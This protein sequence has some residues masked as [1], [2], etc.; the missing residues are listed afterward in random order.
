MPAR[1]SQA[2]LRGL[3]QYPGPVGS[4]DTVAA[5]LL[6]PGLQVGPSLLAD[7]A[8]GD[9]GRL[10]PIVRPG[11]LGRLRRTAPAVSALGQPATAPC[12]RPRGESVSERFRSI[13]QSAADNCRRQR[14]KERDSAER[15]QHKS[16]V[17][18]C[19]LLDASDSSYINSGYANCGAR[20]TACLPVTAAG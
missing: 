4:R 6:G 16:A 19:P 3:D 18:P 11:W 5:R 1:S 14:G 20:A 7:I 8:V 15:R 9:G 12:P 2:G 17:M 10:R 13:S